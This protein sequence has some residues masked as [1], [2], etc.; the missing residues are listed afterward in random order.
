MRRSVL[1]VWIRSLRLQ[2]R[3]KGY[4]TSPNFIFIMSKHIQRTHPAT[5][6]ITIMAIP[7]PSSL[8]KIED[9]VDSADEEPLKQRD[10]YPKTELEWMATS[11]FNRAI[12]YYVGDNDANCKLWAEKAITVAQWLEDG[13][14]LRDTLMEK[15]AALQLDK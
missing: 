8:I 9:D 5:T 7:P 11:A 1:N 2:Q 4:V 10:H 12:D 6:P 14:Q 3:S 13:G 15:F